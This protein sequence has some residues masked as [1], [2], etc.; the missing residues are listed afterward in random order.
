MTD[1]KQSRG[2]SVL[3]ILKTAGILLAICACSA[4]LVSVVNFV[5]YEKIQNNLKNALDHAIAEIFP[6]FGDSEEIAGDYA[7]EV[8][9]VYRVTDGQTVLGYCVEVAP[10]GYGG[11]INMVVGVDSAGAVVGIRIFDHNE[12]KN[13]GDRVAKAEYLSQYVGKSGSLTA[14][15]VDLISG[16]TVSSKAVLN[17]VNIALSAISA[18]EGGLQ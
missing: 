6:D 16:A 8:H 4:L 1:K 13:I 5:T 18:G 15:D 17:G 12:T 11:A 7:A 9:G 14:G 2:G 10:N 3:D